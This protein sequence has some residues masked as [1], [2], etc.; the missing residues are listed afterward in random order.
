[1]RLVYFSLVDYLRVSGH[2]HY[3]DVVITHKVKTCTIWE[4]SAGILE[5]NN[6]KRNRTMKK[7]KIWSI[8]VLTAT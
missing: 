8:W 5:S 7:Y 3:A 6:L 4:D 2:S 1:M